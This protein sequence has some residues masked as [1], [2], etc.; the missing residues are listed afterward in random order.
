MNAHLV[1]S[2][3]DPLRLKHIPRSFS[4]DLGAYLDI[5]RVA[6]NDE[7]ATLSRAVSRI[8]TILSSVN[9]QV[10]IA[11]S[12]MDPI[13]RLWIK[14]G[15]LR[16]IKTVCLQHGVYGSA[17]PDFAQEED[18]VDRYIAL[19]EAQYGIVARNIDKRKI[20]CLGAPASFVWS[21]PA[22]GLKICFV[23]EDWERYGYFDL[24]REIIDI[25]R[26][27][28]QALYL[29]GI[30]DVFYKPHPSEKQFLGIFDV[31][32]K[33]SSDATH[34]PDVYIGFSS[35][36]LRDMASKGKLAIQVHDQSAGIDNFQSR[37][38]CISFDKN[39]DFINQILLSV[40][41]AQEVPCVRE[42][43]LEEFLL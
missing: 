8:N 32:K 28:A 31:M 4:Y 29:F 19:D 5:C 7:R 30:K 10:L 3:R 21:P 17:I 6:G 9:P 35:S 22:C 40:A 27:V 23:G 15:E 1:A 26:D 39:S 18:I 37:G 33:L 24:K 25:Y 42:R 43:A 38:Y 12:T 13:N 16:N 20:E 11:N 14:S 34:I 2:A 36:L 41:H